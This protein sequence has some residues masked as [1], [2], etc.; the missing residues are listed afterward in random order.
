MNDAL[1][2]Q[3]ISM[4]GYPTYQALT[5]FVRMISPRITAASRVPL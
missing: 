2:G 3:V 1:T 4:S 5:R